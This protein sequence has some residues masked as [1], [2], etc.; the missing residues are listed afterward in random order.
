MT[1]SM[2]EL[3]TQRRVQG[4]DEWINVWQEWRRVFPDIKGT[5]QNILVS[6][7]QGAEEVTWEG[8]FRGDLA[9]PGRTIPATGGRIE[10]FPTAFVF[11][12][13]G[14][15]VKEIHNYFDLTTLLQGIGATPQ[16]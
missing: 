5:V 8:T 11:T 7:N 15:K 16:G 14:R 6:G 12:V 10:Q 13:E 1:S 9:F 4:R 2:N 3:G